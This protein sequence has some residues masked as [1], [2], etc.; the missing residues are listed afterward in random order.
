MRFPNTL[1]MWR[2]FDLFSRIGFTGDYISDREALERL[3]DTTDRKEREKM[4][5]SEERKDLQRRRKAIGSS[6]LSPPVVDAPDV[7]TANDV[8]PYYLSTP[9]DL[10]CFNG[11]TARTSDVESEKDFWKV[12]VSNGGPV[13]DDFLEHTIQYWLDA[14]LGYFKEQLKTAENFIDAMDEL[15]KYDTNS[16]RQFMR[17]VHPELKDQFKDYMDKHWPGQGY[18]EELEYPDEVRKG[19]GI[20]VRYLRTNSHTLT[21][22]VIN[23]IETWSSGTSMYDAAL[24]ETVMEELDFNYAEDV[25]WKCIQYVL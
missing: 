11:I 6:N 23:W 20:T 9:S 8:I 21:T 2:T 12:S 4:R 19:Y 14:K 3:S 22:Q 24:T 10:K 15:I 7:P 18:K 13:P 5:L 16:T 17:S 25:A 1:P